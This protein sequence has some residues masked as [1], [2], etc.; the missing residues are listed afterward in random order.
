MLSKLKQNR[1]VEIKDIELEQK[2]SNHK[3][4]LKHKK[5]LFKSGK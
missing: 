2:I 5:L 4:I 3:F 1:Q